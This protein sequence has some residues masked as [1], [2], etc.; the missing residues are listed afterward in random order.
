MAPGWLADFAYCT[1]DPGAF[2]AKSAIKGPRHR[3]FAKIP[4]CT[5]LI[6]A[7]P[8]LMP[9]GLSY[10]SLLRRESRWLVTLARLE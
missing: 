4:L 8:P 2:V 3:A 1:S 9:K 10:Y 6:Q 7:T 5:R